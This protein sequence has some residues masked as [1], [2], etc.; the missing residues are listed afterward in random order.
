MP[1][2]ITSP[3]ECETNA[4]C[5]SQRLTMMENLSPTKLESLANAFSKARIAVI[6]DLMLD[7]YVFGHV[8]RLSP[9]APVPILEFLREETRLGGAANVAHNI[10]TLGG[11]VLLFGVIGNHSGNNDLFISKCNECGMNADD[12]SGV[13]EDESRTTTV[14][15]RYISSFHHL[16]VDYESRKDISAEIENKLLAKLE[17]HF[18]S[19][20]AIILEDYNKGV[21]TKRLIKEITGLA[22]KNAIPV[23]VDPKHDN[24]F[25]Y[26]QATVFKP[27]RKEMEDALGMHFDGDGK[28]SE[29]GFK[30]LDMLQA[31]N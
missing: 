1:A 4:L 24:F 18:S 28:L 29:A 9:E 3:L 19:I 17:E 25:E 27:N 2:P 20:D 13:I 12:I 26:K 11:N 7:R 31:E 16:R 14:K 10:K 21:L 6:G 8:N 15:T 5:F 22:K 23:F 30:L